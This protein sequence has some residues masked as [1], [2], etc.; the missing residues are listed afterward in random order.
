[1]TPSELRLAMLAMKPLSLRKT[2]TPIE[3]LTKNLSL[4]AFEETLVTKR[5]PEDLPTA[6]STLWM[7]R[8]T[9]MTFKIG[10]ASKSPLLPAPLT[11]LKLLLVTLTTNDVHCKNTLIATELFRE[12]TPV[13]GRSSNWLCCLTCPLT[14]FLNILSTMVI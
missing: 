6:R 9:T 4:K 7:P 2:V 8:S 12:I 13:D 11:L 3:T 14:T 1:M 5:G 10:L